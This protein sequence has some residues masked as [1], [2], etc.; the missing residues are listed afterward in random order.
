[1]NKKSLL[2]VSLFSAIAFAGV[3]IEEQQAQLAQIKERQDSLSEYASS[4]V[5]GKDDSPVSL[6]G[7]FFTRV[8]NMDFSKTSILFEGGNKARTFFDAGLSLELGVNPNSFVTFWATLF[9]PFDFSGY[10]TNSTACEPNKLP[11]NYP[12]K[13]QTHHSL[14]FYSTSM[15]ENVTVG[16]DVRGGEFGARL[17]AGG[18]LWTNFSP[19]TVWE[20]QAWPQFIS[21]F[22]TYEWERNVSTYY[23]EKS[24]KLVEEGGRAFWSNRDFGGLWLDIYKMPFGLTG[25]L[26]LSQAKGDDQGTR[27]GIRALGS[28]PGEVELAGTLDFRSDVLAARVAKNDIGPMALGLN[29]VGVL[30]DRDIAYEINS[31]AGT[32]FMGSSRLPNNP[33]LN[34]NYVASMDIKGNINPKLYITL[35][36]ALS[37]DDST[38][39]VWDPEGI[40]GGSRHVE[41]NTYYKDRTTS[42]PEFA[43]HAKVQNKYLIPAVLE[44]SY[45]MPNFY[46]PYGMTDYGRNR[47]WRKDL[48]PLGAGAYRYAPNLMGANIKLT[49]EFN[50]GRFNVIY[51]QHRQVEA[52]KDVLIFPYRLTGRNQWEA[53]ASWSK[54]NPALRYDD[55]YDPDSW[56]KYYNR[57]GGGKDFVKENY[58]GGLRGGTWEMWEYFG[59]FESIRDA[60]NGNLTQTAKWSSVLAFDMGYDIGHWFGTDRNIFLAANTALSSISGS[61]N[62]VPYSEKASETML[63]SWFLQ[64]EPAFAITDNLHGILIAGLEIFRA[65]NVY[66]YSVVGQG[67]SSDPVTLIKGVPVYQFM[68]I[69]YLETAYGAGFDWDFAPRAGLHVRY[70]YAT[71]RDETNPINDWKG[72]FINAE[73]K[74]WF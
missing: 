13:M 66:G 50:R 31:A 26:L 15:W 54:Y 4:T 30:H 60:A 73:T 44:A 1:M 7:D 58:L 22:E 16:I 19:L 39:Y 20:R 65:P 17:S 63:W 68:P 52:G 23:K 9:F 32:D 49:P 21:Q 57:V 59:N 74:V 51:A 47:T 2:F 6:S 8:R 36:I 41:Q 48:M 45:I 10:F 67:N 18:V 46:S 24:F 12:C 53:T 40:V 37:L 3:G 62:P 5:I 71:H 29:F 69:N 38:N 33:Y 72:H 42:S 35:D 27:D 43:V 34:D 11:N 55:G 56:A 28:Q 14:D 25:Q 61:I 64:A 70:K